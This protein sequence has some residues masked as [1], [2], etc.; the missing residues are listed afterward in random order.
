M[1]YRPSIADQATDEPLAWRPGAALDVL[2]LRAQLAAA[3]RAFF[4][5]RD[6]LEVETP[7]LSRAATPE[8]AIDSLMTRYRGPG[9]PRGQDLYLH[10][11]PEYFMKRL[12]AAG[13]GPVYQLARVFRD[14]EAGARHNPEFTL[15]EW[16]RPGFD[17]HAL[18][19]EVEALL[20]RLPGPWAG[21][22]PAQRLS[23]REL[24]LRHADLDPFTA[25][26]RRLRERLQAAGVTPPAGLANGETRQWLDLVLTHLI[27]PQ[28][29]AGAYF[30]YDYP[31]EQAAL[32]RVRAGSPPLA[33][34]FELYVNGVEL[35]NGFHELTDAAEQ[36]ARFERE[37]RARQAAGRAPVLI[38]EHF[39]AAL[40]AGLPA[41][42][43]VALG[44]DRLVMLAAGLAHIDQAMAFSHARL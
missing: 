14:G 17:H 24:F 44:F 2:R 5:E 42:A 18:M 36:R 27:E 9:A 12:L 10:S 41:A 15:L 34:R 4:A 22:G 21:S 16:Y 11:S 19:D 28:L 35:A 3:V 26:A 29:G 37:N 23:Y 20:G 39:L 43:G 33:E 25:D 31:A 32:A 30:V 1:Q 38:D 13:S 7:V 8:P 6:V 40:Q